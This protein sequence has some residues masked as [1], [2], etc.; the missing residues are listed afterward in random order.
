MVESQFGLSKK[1]LL[2]TGFSFSNMYTHKQQQVESGSF[3]AKYRFLSKDALHKHF[4]AAA[5]MNVVVSRNNLRYEELTTDGDHSVFQAG[6]IA[7]QLINKLALSGTLALT[8]I[9][10]AERWEKKSAPAKYGYQ[11]L[12][13]SFSGGYLLFPRKYTSYKQTNLNLYIELIGGVGLDRTFSY[14]DLAPAVQFIFN[15]NT[16]VNMGYRFQ[17]NGNTYRMARTGVYVS[18]ERTFLNVLRK[19]N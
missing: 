11:G 5:F 6:I 16:K 19:R 18:F 14:T 9:I 10:N 13:Y 4:R 12:N 3:Y 7:T 15:S 17:L 8:E 2:K 1:L